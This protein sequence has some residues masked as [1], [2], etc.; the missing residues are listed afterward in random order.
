MAAKLE[1]GQ[2]AGPFE[3]RARDDAT[4]REL[5][6][7]R[8]RPRHLLVCRHSPAFRQQS[9]RSI[10]AR[11]PGHLDTIEVSIGYPLATTSSSAGT[12][13]PSQRPRAGLLVGTGHQWA[14]MSTGIGGPQSTGTI[15]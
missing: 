7:T 11:I 8:R 10:H 5:F 13:N 4:F 1:L 12:V 6:Y 9:G 2:A 15:H 3:A 14:W